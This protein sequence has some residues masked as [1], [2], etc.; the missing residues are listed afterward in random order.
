MNMTAVLKE[1]ESWPLDD[2]VELVQR[3][4]D[5]LV[6]SGWQPDLTDELKAELDRRLD[7]LEANPNDVVS[8]ESVVEHVRRKR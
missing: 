6:E 3:V 2:Q 4:W 7:A 8:W 1:I 5:R